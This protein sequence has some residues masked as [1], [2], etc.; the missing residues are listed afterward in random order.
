MVLVEFGMIDMM[1]E[2][3]IF[4]EGPES[5]GSSKSAQLV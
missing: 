4:L 1:I 5:T 3:G 2:T